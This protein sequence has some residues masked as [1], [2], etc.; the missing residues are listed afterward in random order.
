MCH[1]KKPSHGLSKLTTY[2]RSTSGTS[3]HFYLWLVIASLYN[4]GE[5]IQANQGSCHGVTPWAPASPCLHVPLWKQARKFKYHASLGYVDTLDIMPDA[6]S[7]AQFLEILNSQHHN[8]NFAMELEINTR[9]HLFPGMQITR[10]GDQLHTLV[11]RK[12]YDTRCVITTSFKP[13]GLSL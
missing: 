11:Y 1:S 6:E 2:E 7:A 12:P 9:F 5:L 10:N 13:C 4:N 8:L 3:W